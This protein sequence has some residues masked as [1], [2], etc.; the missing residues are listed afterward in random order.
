MYNVC[1]L[2]KS[3]MHRKHNNIV[4]F[5]I[6]FGK[7]YVMCTNYS[8]LFNDKYLKFIV[9]SI[10]WQH[11]MHRVRFP[12]IVCIVRILWSSR[13]QGRVLS[14]ALLIEWLLHLQLAFIR[15]V[16][17]NTENRHCCD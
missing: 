13:R 14:Q 5:S 1:L 4:A 6:T 7:T 9:A 2:H 10:L 11:D 16:C 15:T 3:H 8:A 17:N 12:Y